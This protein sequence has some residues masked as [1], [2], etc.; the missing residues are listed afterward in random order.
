MRIEEDCGHT[1]VSRQVTGKREA[2]LFSFVTIPRDQ[3]RC[4][5]RKGL[6]LPPTWVYLRKEFWKQL[7]I[8]RTQVLFLSIL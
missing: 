2:Y 1:P 7:G 3:G 6:N 8:K 5:I 4:G